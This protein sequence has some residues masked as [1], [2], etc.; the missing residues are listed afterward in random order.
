MKAPFKLPVRVEE[1][2][3]LCAADSELIC[4]LESATP[5]EIAFI[6]EAVNEHATLKTRVKQLEDLYF[7]LVE[8]LA[9]RF[10]ALDG[11]RANDPILKRVDRW[12]RPEPEVAR[13]AGLLADAEVDF[14]GSA[15]ELEY[16]LDQ[17]RREI[18]RS[19]AG[20]YTEWELRDLAV[21]RGLIE[22]GE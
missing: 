2:G 3:Y 9:E 6:F 13:L 7:G 5:Q 22:E 11:D 20:T 17:A 10:P 12:M 16:L 8:A 19:L 18:A 14:D 21:E 4:R 15:A 1:G